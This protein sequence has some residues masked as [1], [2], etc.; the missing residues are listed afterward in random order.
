M[1]Q[2]HYWEAI[3]RSADQEILGRLQF[4]LGFIVRQ[5][6][7]VYTFTPYVFKIHFNIILTERRGRVVHTPGYYSG[8]PGFKCRSGDLLSWR[9]FLEFFLSPSRQMPG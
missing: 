6:N 1:K 4:A 5:I 3:S 2:S 8:S 7:P 9:K